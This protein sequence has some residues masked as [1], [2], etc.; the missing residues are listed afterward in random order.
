MLALR[1]KVSW[2]LNNGSSIGVIYDSRGKIIS[3]VI[4][5]Y[6]HV[7]GLKVERLNNRFEL[8]QTCQNERVPD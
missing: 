1:L 2:K 5:I 6:I 7:F 8:F 4:Y 3:I